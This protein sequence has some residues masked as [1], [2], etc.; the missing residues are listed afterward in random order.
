MF[1]VHLRRICTLLLLGEMLC[2]CLFI[3]SYV[4]F[5]FSVSLLIFCL[6]DQSS[7]E[8]GILKSFAIIELL[9]IFPFGS[10]NIYFI[11]LGVPV[12]GS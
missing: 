3:L 10:A 9:S 12:L 4:W 5:Q 7:V 2:I 1:H 11:R 8:S 6:D